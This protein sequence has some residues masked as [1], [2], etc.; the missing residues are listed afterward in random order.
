MPGTNNSGGSIGFVDYGFA[1]GA[2]L[3][4]TTG[5]ADGVAIAQVYTTTASATTTLAVAKGASASAVGAAIVEALKQVAAST[6]IYPDA[7]GSLVSTFYYVTNGNPNPAEAAFI[8]FVASPA[9][10]PFF[11]SQ[12]YFSFIEL[13]S[14]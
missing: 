14:S 4:L 11:T 10:E 7:G 1:T 12:G 13:G 9:G 3:G 6:D 8:G 5:N 2:A